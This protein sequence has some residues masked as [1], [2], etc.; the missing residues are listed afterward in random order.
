MSQ[1]N[2]IN[3]SA[4]LL[5]SLSQLSENELLNAP[6]ISLSEEEVTMNFGGKDK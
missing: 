4:V 2:E 1:E 6:K 3:A 5:P